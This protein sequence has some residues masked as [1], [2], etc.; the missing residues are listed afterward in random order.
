MASSFQGEPR[1]SSRSRPSTIQPA[2]DA[3][4][5]ERPSLAN[6]RHFSWPRLSPSQGGTEAGRSLYDVPPSRATPVQGTS[7]H[8]ARKFSRYREIGSSMSLPKSRT[9]VGP[10][11]RPS[12]RVRHR[13]SSPQPRY[14]GDTNFQY[15]SLDPRQNEIRLLQVL[16][17]I[18]TKIQCQIF[19]TSLKVP[20]EYIAVSYS[21]GD[22]LDTRLI[23]LDGHEFPVT[24]NLWQALS[25]IRSVSSKVVVWVDAICINQNDLE[26]RSYQVGLMTIIYQKAMMV[27]LWLGP[28]ANDSYVATELLCELAE[29]KGSRRALVSIIND[30]KRGRHWNALVDL[31]ERDYW[32]RLWV[33]QEIFHARKV[34]VLCGNSAHPWEVYLEASELLRAC[35]EDLTRGFHLEQGRQALSKNWVTYSACLVDLGPSTLRSLHSLHTAGEADLFS[36]LLLCADKSCRDPRDKLYAL[37]G[38]L[39]ESDRSQFHVNYKLDPRDVYIDIVDYVISKTDRLDIIC[40]AANPVFAENIHMLPSWVPDWSR[41]SSWR[42]PLNEI[43]NTRFN[44]ARDTLA[45]SR[46][47]GQRRK[48]SITGII[49][50]TADVVGVGIETSPSTSAY[51][52]AFLQWYWAF[53]SQKSPASDFDHAAFCRT[54]SLGRFKYPGYTARDM[55]GPTYQVFTRL[56]SERYGA[57]KPDETMQRYVEATPEL[58]LDK[59]THAIE[60]FKTAMQGRI[61]VMTVSGLFCLA[62]DNVTANDIVC[63]AYGCSTPIVLRMHGEEFRFVGECY[64]DGYMEGRALDERVSGSR[65][66]REFILV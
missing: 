16:P 8:H 7:R 10:S 48:L 25:R 29:C 26:E 4:T 5:A 40:C 30:Q 61:F 14:L 59:I 2:L 28:E 37:L 34:T 49:L 57:F 65:E 66:L 24:T 31:F 41:L 55:V 64:V 51:L 47:F 56:L 18:S 50:G 35:K 27:A 36:C 23:V 60:D 45:S 13:S 63:V 44:A 33:V 22:S 17:D 32:R 6:T 58:S 54:V 53:S 11:E 42:R 62:S 52:M 19:H 21:W 46:L 20:H 43:P 15:Q 12:K 3:G 38:I 1:K 9:A 39:S